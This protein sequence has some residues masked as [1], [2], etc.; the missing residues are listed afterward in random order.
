MICNRKTILLRESWNLRNYVPAW[1]RRH[2]PSVLIYQHIRNKVILYFT[3]RVWVRSFSIP[4]S[5]KPESPR[6]TRESGCSVR[7]DIRHYKVSYCSSRMT[8][9]LPSVDLGCC[10]RFS[11]GIGSSRGIRGEKN[12]E[13]GLARY[14]IHGCSWG[15]SRISSFHLGMNKLYRFFVLRT[16]NE[17]LWIAVR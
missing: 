8:F 13:I 7:D 3:E 14:I 11:W 9:F 15:C 10:I 5:M 2:R 17:S 6:N 1:W 4:Q 12:G 16:C